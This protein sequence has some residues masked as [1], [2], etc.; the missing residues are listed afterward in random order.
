[1]NEAERDRLN[2]AVADA[3]GKVVAAVE[4]QQR[5]SIR[6]AVE[7]GWRDRD[8][9]IIAAHELKDAYDKRAAAVLRLPSA[10]GSTN[11]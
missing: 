11:G 8:A 2:D 10:E 9:V 4:R 7:S 3:V 5:R 1:M 6:E